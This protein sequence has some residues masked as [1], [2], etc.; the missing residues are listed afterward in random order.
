M[1][2]DFKKFRP[3]WVAS[4]RGC[5]LCDGTIRR[6]DIPPEDLPQTADR[7]YLTASAGKASQKS[8]LWM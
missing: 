3:T 2:G 6:G 1:F 7:A 8:D 4:D 5:Q